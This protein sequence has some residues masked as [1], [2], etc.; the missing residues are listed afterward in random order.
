MTVLSRI[1]TKPLIVAAAVAMPLTACGQSSDTG[2]S[3]AAK[4]KMETMVDVPETTIT[5]GTYA[6]DPTHTSMAVSLIHLGFA[7]YAVQFADVDATLDLDLENPAN[8]T[9]SFD[10]AADSVFTSYRGDYKATHKN[11]DHDTWEEAVAKDFLGAE[12]Q[13]IITFRSTRF[14][15]EGGMT[16]TVYGDLAMNGITKPAEFDI[17][18]TG[19]GLHPFNQKEGVGVV[20]EGTVTRADYDIAQSMNNFLSDEVTINFSADFLKAAE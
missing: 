9:V 3:L 2:E 16:G 13:N 11:S 15:Y 12:T 14:D 6:N 7:P 8:S 1:L 10:L 17:Q 18:I 4:A 19:E 5:S 20:A